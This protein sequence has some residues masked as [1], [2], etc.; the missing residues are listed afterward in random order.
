MISISDKGK[1]L[2]ALCL[3]K[4][5]LHNKAQNLNKE[6]E[7]IISLYKTMVSDISKAQYEVL[8]RMQACDDAIAEISRT[9]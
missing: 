9:I 7:N 1:A 2:A 6:M 5:K 3:E 8:A 4:D